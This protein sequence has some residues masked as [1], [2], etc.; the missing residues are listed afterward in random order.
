MG[1]AEGRFGTGEMKVNISAVAAGLG[2]NWGAHEP[3]MDTSSLITVEAHGRGVAGDWIGPLPAGK[4]KLSV[5]YVA[6]AHR[7]WTYCRMERGADL[8]RGS[9]ERWQSVEVS[10]LRTTPGK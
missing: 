10:M 4:A 5:G 9:Y 3:A 1:V 7:G 2:S 6:R 8:P